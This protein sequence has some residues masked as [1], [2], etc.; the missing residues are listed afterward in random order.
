ML[1]SYKYYD[2]EVEEE[3]LSN[4]AYW[5]YNYLDLIAGEMVN[6]ASSSNT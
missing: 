1:Q 6:D 5:S 2:V 3:S 4:V